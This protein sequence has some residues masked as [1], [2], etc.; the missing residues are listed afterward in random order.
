MAI[1]I[2][3]FY[4]LYIN[5]LCILAALLQ[6]FCEQYIYRV[7]FDSISISFQLFHIHFSNKTNES[8]NNLE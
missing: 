5:K 3:L 2:H 1:E 4:L 7:S 8:L 6:Q